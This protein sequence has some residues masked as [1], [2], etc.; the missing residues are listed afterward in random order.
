ML[1]RRHL[2]LQEIDGE[3][4]RYKSDETVDVLALSPEAGVDGKVTDEEYGDDEIAA[5]GADTERIWYF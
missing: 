1:H 4:F 5:T 2:R 3:L